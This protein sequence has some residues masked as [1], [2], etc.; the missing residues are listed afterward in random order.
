MESRGC[1]WTPL[2]NLDGRSEHAMCLVFAV[3]PMNAVMSDQS[4]TLRSG[5]ITIP[6]SKWLISLLVE[7]ILE[8]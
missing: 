7:R 8:Q 6:I 3:I 2:A 5:D 4:I 1:L